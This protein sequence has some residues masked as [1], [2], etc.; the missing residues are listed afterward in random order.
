MVPEAGV[1]PADELVLSQWPLPFGYT[2]EDGASGETRTP[3][4]AGSKPVRCASFQLSHAR[5][6]VPTGG[7]ESPRV[8]LQNS[9]SPSE[10]RRRE[11]LQTAGIAPA[12]RNSVA[13]QKP[14]CAAP[15]KETSTGSAGRLMS[16]Q[17]RPS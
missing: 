16:S 5:E 13:A 3:K 8:C 11:N 14:P 2:G 17:G 12:K 15:P 6:M 4:A 7:L 1:E 9:C 10:L